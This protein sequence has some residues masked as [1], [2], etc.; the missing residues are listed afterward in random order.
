VADHTWR[1]WRRTFIRRRFPTMRQRSFELTGDENK[2]TKFTIESAAAGP[3][4]QGHSG[5]KSLDSS[6]SNTST[7]YF[8][9]QL[10]PPTTNNMLSIGKTLFLSACMLAGFTSAADPA[11][12]TLT[13]L[14]SVTFTGGAPIDFGPTPLGNL[15]FTPL[16]GGT[17]SGPRLKGMSSQ[18]D[19]CFPKINA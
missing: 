16:T 4:T 15:S 3:F 1:M 12:P 8:H 17:F 9:N 11:K 7:I 14:Y 18:E 5:S 19:F 13:Y 2:F 10:N 6:I